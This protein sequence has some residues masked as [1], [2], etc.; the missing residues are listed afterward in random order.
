MIADHEKVLALA[1]VIGGMESAVS[2][3][4]RTIIWESACFDPAAVRLSAQRHGIRTDASTRY[5][6]SLDPLLA[7]SGITRA[8]EYMDFLQK[9]YQITQ[10]ESHL[11]THS[12][13]LIRLHVTREQIIEKLGVTIDV[14]TFEGI[15]SRLGF[16]YQH[17]I[18]DPSARELTFQ[19]LV[20]VPSWRAT[21]DID[22]WEDIAEE[23]G[24]VSGYDHITEQLIPS[25][26]GISAPD[27][28]LTLRNQTLTHWSH[29]GWIEGYHY[30][31]SSESLDLQIGYTDMESAIR[32]ENAFNEEYTHM[33]RSLIPR[34]LLSVAENVKHTERFSLFELGQVFEKSMTE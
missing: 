7:E 21:K 2:R 14:D 31:F 10:Y 6:K 17:R 5:E 23:V 11:D 28:R 24:R 18:L 13:R 25:D 33:R 27:P 12:V 30:S 3:E 16:H 1:G 29:R 8:I 15:L 26:F 22:I 19:Y 34:L 20:T 4:T 9:S 32:V